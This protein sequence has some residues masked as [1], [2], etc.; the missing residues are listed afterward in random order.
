MRG[1]CHEWN[2]MNPGV[3][4]TPEDLEEDDGE[5]VYDDAERLDQIREQYDDLYHHHA[6]EV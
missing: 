3:P 4:L 1:L 6:Y 2:P 5:Y